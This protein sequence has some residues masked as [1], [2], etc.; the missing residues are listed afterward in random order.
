M[1]S[2]RAS[3]KRRFT[4]IIQNIIGKNNNNE[5]LTR[6]IKQLEN[7]FMHTI[8]LAN[9]LGEMR[10]PSIAGHDRQ[11]ANIA[12][13]I[14]K[15][16]GFDEQ[17][18][19]GLRISG[20]LHDIGN[21][22]IPAGILAKSHKLS[23][24]EYVLVMK[25]PISG[26]DLLKDVE[27]PWPVAT[28]V[29]QHHERIDGSGYPNGLKGEQIILESRIIAV[30]DVVEAMASHRPYRPSFSIEETLVEIQKGS[31][32]IYDKDVAQICLRIFRENLC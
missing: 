32:R 25:H 28:V 8:E 5:H 4:G 18:L 14:G 2:N 3:R 29:L 9:A 16:M 15:K 23:K 10:D 6:Y 13:A 17:R 22:I 26:F 31:G 20:H 21:M 30:A 27:F 7:V 11:V 12:V 24:A 1:N 19:D